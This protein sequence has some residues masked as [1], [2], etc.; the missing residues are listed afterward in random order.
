MRPRT[1]CKQVGTIFKV[2]A[3]ND[4]RPSFY[5]W[6]SAQSVRRPGDEVLNTNV[7]RAGFRCVTPMPIYGGTYRCAFQPHYLIILFQTSGINVDVI[8]PRALICEQ[9]AVQLHFVGV[10][11]RPVIPVRSFM[12]CRLRSIV[13]PTPPTSS[14][15]LWRTPGAHEPPAVRASA[16]GGGRVSPSPPPTRRISVI[17][18]L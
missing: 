10:K 9:V 6:I 11:P 18:R 5:D 14:T 8:F 4:V 12:V 1:G 17:P 3:N 2:P 13:I 16:D 15:S 7:C